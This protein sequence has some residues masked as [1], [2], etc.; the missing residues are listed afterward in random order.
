MNSKNETCYKY[1]LKRSILENLLIPILLLSYVLVC[2]ALVLSAKYSNNTTNEYEKNS[3]M[4]PIVLSISDE[5][6]IL[7]F[8]NN[9]VT[10]P[11]PIKMKQ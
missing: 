10:T 1:Y 9:G 11:L 6:K 8:G 7:V 5:N 2:G 4:K 3:L